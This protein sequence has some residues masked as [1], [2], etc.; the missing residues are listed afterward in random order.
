MPDEWL[1]ALSHSLTMNRIIRNPTIQP[2]FEAFSD[3][4]NDGGYRR[5]GGRDRIQVILP[6]V[7][8][9]IARVVGTKDINIPIIA[10]ISHPGIVCAS[11]KRLL[12]KRKI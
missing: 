4:I 8:R 9:W 7:Y 12:G 10:D 5:S 2:T 1:S 6:Q 11:G 3:G